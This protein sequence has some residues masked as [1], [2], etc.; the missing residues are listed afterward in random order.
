[1]AEKSEVNK[2]YIISSSW[3]NLSLFDLGKG[4]W[5]GITFSILNLIF[6]LRFLVLGIGLRNELPLH[7][8]VIFISCS[9]IS[10]FLAIIGINR[11]FVDRIYAYLEDN[12]TVYQIAIG[13]LVVREGVV[14]IL[15]NL[16]EIVYIE[17]GGWFIAISLWLFLCWGILS[18]GRDLS[19]LLIPNM[20]KHNNKKSIFYYL[21][22]ILPILL[23]VGFWILFHWIN[24]DLFYVNYD[25]EIPYMFNSFTPFIDL[26]LY[27]RMDHPG[28][29][30]QLLGSAFYVIT[31]PLSIYKTDPI[32]EY[33]IKHPA[34]FLTFARAFLLMINILTI[35]VIFRREAK[36]N[37]WVSILRAFSVGYF[38]FAIH[39]DS[40]SFLTIWSPNAFNFAVGTLLL[41]SLYELLKTNK[42]ITKQEEYAVGFLF[43]VAATFQVYMIVWIFGICI[44]IFVYRLLMTSNWGKS[45]QSALRVGSNAIFGYIITTLI[46]L[47]HYRSFFG[48]VSGIF[49]HQGMYGAGPKGIG[50]LE[51]FIF[52][53][54]QLWSYNLALILCTVVIGAILFFIF[55][56]F[57]HRIKPPNWMIAISI[58]SMVQIGLLSFL[59]IKH[60]ANRYLLSIA[61]ILPILLLIVIELI[62]ELTSNNRKIYQYS[63][64]VISVFVLVGFLGNWISTNRSASERASYLHQYENEVERF[65]S[66]YTDK[67]NKNRDDVNILWTYGSYSR[68]YALNLGAGYAKN[69][70][71]DEVRQTCPN[72]Q[73]LVVWEGVNSL[74]HF[75]DWDVIIGNPTYLETYGFVDSGTLVNTKL[76]DLIFIISDEH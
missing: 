47:P 6:S 32:I 35:I 72:E 52:N 25:P 36:S 3:P 73:R 75:E 9:L 1:M 53:F 29:I 64:F 71:I 49:T 59:V 76:E 50:S 56:I 61:A 27:N 13:F 15:D 48:W 10:A 63:L 17:L 37:N 5:I 16:L 28:V 21:G 23:L 20:N 55:I 62:E 39:P 60:P 43:G 33:H 30:M 22:L 54:K 58:G 2:N 19:L 26:S 42:N 18:L 7:H 68:C 41:F 40:F 69:M 8:V 12:S 46:I 45:I 70:I 31:Y 34:V 57:R 66:S 74:E 38:Y 44:T 67:Y 11:A 65:L 51:Q 24:F 14:W 4:K